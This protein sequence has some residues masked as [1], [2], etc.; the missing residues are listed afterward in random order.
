MYVEVNKYSVN[1]CCSK[2]TCAVM[3]PYKFCLQFL[4]KT[5]KMSLDYCISFDQDN[6]VYSYTPI[7]ITGLF[8]LYNP[9]ILFIQKTIL[10]CLFFLYPAFDIRYIKVNLFLQIP[11]YL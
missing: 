5:V 4:I 9:I 10:I 3:L 8:L 7:L 1:L 6:T 2:L 11:V